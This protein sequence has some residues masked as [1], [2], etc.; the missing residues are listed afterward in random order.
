MP[1][2]K[3]KSFKHVLEKEE[4]TFSSKSYTLGESPIHMQRLDLRVGLLGVWTFKKCVLWEVLKP[5]GLLP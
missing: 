2:K 1:K 3:K 4:K 5:L